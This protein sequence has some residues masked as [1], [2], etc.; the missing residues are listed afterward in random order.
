MRVSSYRKETR[1]VIL[2]TDK[3][4]VRNVAGKEIGTGCESCFFDDLALSVTDGCARRGLSW[5][6]IGGK[7][8][9]MRDSCPPPAFSCAACAYGRA[10]CSLLYFLRE[11][12]TG[13]RNAL[14]GAAVKW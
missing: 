2:R 5:R 13:S 3:Y 12:V 6:D 14:V 11:R 9:F 10:P 4:K 8:D 7:P 1:N